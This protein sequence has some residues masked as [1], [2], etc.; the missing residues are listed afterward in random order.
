GGLRIIGVAGSYGKTTMKEVLQKVLSTKY[1][2]LSTPESVNT[3]VG[4]ARF[5]LNKVDE[6]CQVLILE[7]GEHY[8]GDIKALCQIAPLDVS[9]ITGINE[10]H[11]ERLGSLDNVVATIFEAAEFGKNDALVV[12]NADDKLVAANYK[13]F[14]KPTQ[15][16]EK[17][18]ISDIQDSKFSA[19]GLGWTGKVNGVEVEIRLL[20]EYALADASAAVTVGKHLGLSDQEICMGLLA[21]RPVEHR[22]QPM[23]SAANVL[24]ID[25]SY[26]GNPAGAAEAVKVLERFLGRR[27]IYLTPGLVETG[28]AAPAVH[29]E[30]GRRLAGVADVVILIKNSV[31]GYIEEGIKQQAI[32]NRPQIIWFAGA[33]AAHEGLK[34]IVKSGDV[35][36]LQND[37]GDQYL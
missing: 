13:K 12:L 18:Q 6:Q 26:N 8:R 9:V 20:G 19:A 16:M 3:P 27:K 35:V 14:I 5:V 23:P 37:W 29:R 2:V 4:I 1:K 31:A 34:D 7:L 17:Y 11:L 21:V 10:A 22:L 28:T 33:P 32:G 15:R 30:I 24:V 36:L 25:D